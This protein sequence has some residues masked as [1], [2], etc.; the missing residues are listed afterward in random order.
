MITNA[1]KDVGGEEHHALLV[2]SESLWLLWRQ[3]MEGPQITRSV[4]ISAAPSF[5]QRS[6]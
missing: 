4:Q 5:R 6:F 2:G 3:Y 1:R